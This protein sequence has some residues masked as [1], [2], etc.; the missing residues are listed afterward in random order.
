M[1]VQNV[2]RVTIG[3]SMPLVADGVLAGP[4]QDLAS[5]GGWGGDQ[6]GPGQVFEVGDCFG[7]E[8]DSYEVSVLVYLGADGVLGFG[9]VVHNAPIIDDFQG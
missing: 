4:R 3:C 2:S 8:V 1:Y 7:T 9:V 6:A 5:T